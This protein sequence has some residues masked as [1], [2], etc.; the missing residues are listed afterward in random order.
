[1]V[2]LAIG[3][4]WIARKGNEKKNENKKKSKKKRKL[5]PFEKTGSN[6]ACLC[7]LMLI[8]QK[9]EKEFA[10]C[11]KMEKSPFLSKNEKIVRFLSKK[12]FFFL[13]IEE[14]V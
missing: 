4:L 12:D 2:I 13:E 14:K 7:T 1:M 10:F 3:N 8:L 9:M 6:V 11:S 5:G